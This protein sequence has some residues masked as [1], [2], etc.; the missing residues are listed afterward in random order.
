MTEAQDTFQ[1]PIKV[2]ISDPDTGEELESRVVWNDY[3]LITAGNR[4]LKSMAVMG[5]THTL[6]VGKAKPR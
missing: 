2:T 1:K 5:S 6:H 3:V 4:Y